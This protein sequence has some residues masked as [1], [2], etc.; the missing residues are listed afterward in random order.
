MVAAGVGLAVLREAAEAR[1][2]VEVD[3]PP[4]HTRGSRWTVVFSTW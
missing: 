1:A 3:P 2:E 4:P